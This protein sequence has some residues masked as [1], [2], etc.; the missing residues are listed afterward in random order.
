MHC[1]DPLELQHTVA[2]TIGIAVLLCIFRELACKH[3]DNLC[4]VCVTS[5][6]PDAADQIA[7][8]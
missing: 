2:I 7:S 8:A 4:C 1:C 6:V 5:H 3:K